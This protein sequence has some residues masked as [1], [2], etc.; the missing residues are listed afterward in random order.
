MSEDT[1]TSVFEFR[2]VAPTTEVIG[3]RA[4]ASQNVD[5]SGRPSALLRLL[6]GPDQFMDPNAKHPG[7]NRTRCRNSVQPAQTLLQYAEDSRTGSKTDRRPQI[8]PHTRHHC[9]ERMFVITHSQEL[10]THV[11]VV[12]LRRNNQLRTAGRWFTFFGDCNSASCR[13]RFRHNS[14]W[15]FGFLLRRSWP[16]V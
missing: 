7:L 16:G 4:Q 11:M 8:H 2:S 3:G 1:P 14:G 5:E 15:I 13:L 12:P 10:R 9:A 6:P